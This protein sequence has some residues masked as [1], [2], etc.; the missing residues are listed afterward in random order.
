LDHGSVALLVHVEPMRVTGRL[1]VD[2]HAERHGP[3]RLTRPQDEVDVAGVEAEGDSPIGPVQRA[4]PPLDRPVAGERP[5]VELQRI[6]GE[7]GARLVGRPI[8]AV[9]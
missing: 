3:A 1:S 6:R 9:T 2:E 7:V 4:R 8:N 5:L